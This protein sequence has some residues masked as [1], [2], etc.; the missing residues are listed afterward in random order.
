[1]SRP[2]S[3]PAAQGLSVEDWL[4]THCLA[5]TGGRGALGRR[6][7][8]RLAAS[9]AA[10]VVAID[11]RSPASSDPVEQ[12]SAVDH[13]TA[14]ILDVD[15]MARSLSGCSVVFHLAALTNAAESVAESERYFEIN[16]RGSVLL[17]EACAKAGVRQVIYTSTS[18]VYG[19]PLRLPIDEDHPTDP[20]TPYAASKL[21]GERA[22]A[23]YASHGGGT[24]DIARLANL[25]GASYSSDTAVGVA[26][27]QALHGGPISLRNLAGVR[28]FI[29]ADDV[30]EALVHLAAAPQGAG[31][32]RV[33]N[34]STGIEA[35]VLEV[36]RA[37]AE[38][39]EE[40]G[41]GYPDIVQS[42]EPSDGAAPRI[43]LD[44]RRLA[45]LTGRTPRFNLAQ[46]LATALSECKAESAARAIAG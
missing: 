33:V 3:R 27:N 10:R 34:I 18:L 26:L 24:G 32:C 2:T 45:Q 23:D 31:E 35:S 29:H 8:R 20:L 12:A 46:G 44:N 25:Y 37:I 6:L 38:A 5:V 13:V 41:M 15:E 36:A 28:D 22:V 11:S 40:Q 30:V 19:I 4:K 1:M 16:A 9:G 42:G 17:M 7:V 21:A 43:V 39:A 14:D